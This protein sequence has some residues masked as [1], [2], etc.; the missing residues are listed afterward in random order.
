MNNAI[1]FL[2]PEL[3]TDTWDNLSIG[4]NLFSDNIW[5]LRYLQNN[6]RSGVHAS[7]K[8]NFNLLKKKSLLIEPI[9]RYCYIRLGQV[10]PTTVTGEYSELV[11]KLITFFEEKELTSLHEINTNKFI[12]F[13]VWLRENYRNS[14]LHYLASTCHTL[15]QV[16]N[17]G[18]SLNF[19]NLPKTPIFLE[20]SI[21][22]WWG[23][24][25]QNRKIRL[26]YYE[27]R[28]IPLAIWKKI[29]QCAW[30]EP[31]VLR[32][33]QSGE[34]LGLFRVNN[35]KFGILIQAYTGLRISEVVYLKRGCIEKDSKSLYWLNAAIEKT[36]NETTSHKILIPKIIYDLIMELH[37][38]TKPLCTESD[39]QEYLFYLLSK[40]RKRQPEDT[41]KRLIPRTLESG[42][43]NSYI[44][45]PFLK[46]NNIEA[47]FKNTNNHTIKITSHCFRHTFARIAVAEK[48]VNLSVIQTHYK[49][50]SIEMTSH[51]VNLTKQELKK[52]YVEGML[53]TDAIYTQ[54]K[55]GERFKKYI[56]DAQTI[57][58]FN[59][60][61]DDLSKL[62]GINPLPFGLCLYDFK[63][64][65]CPHLGVQSCYSSGCGDFVTNKTFLP[66]FNN[67]KTLLEKHIEHCKTHDNIIEEKKANFRFDKLKTIIN[68][69]GGKNEG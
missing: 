27:D 3:N 42:K 56:S 53:N 63:K 61:L 4:D 50:L 22:D 44:L 33:I 43:W 17:I 62:F 5:N 2:V 69:I 19:P 34:S 65:H 18:Q 38:L 57:S 6:K 52:S 36:Q 54:G 48:N 11:S 21:W 41:K 8:L 30:E 39:E 66:Y 25:K 47:E 55:E 40:V 1:D 28:S 60:V 49:H 64:G 9:K 46:R 45:R 24:N 15:L 59:E 37:E 35:A 14:S 58:D 10:K 29:I 68:N 23:I 51:Y 20:V 26:G 12:E 13:N 31:N 67:E 16:I 7:G 32:Y